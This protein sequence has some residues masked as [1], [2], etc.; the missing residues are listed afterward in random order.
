MSLSIHRG[1]LALLAGSLLAT[2]CS[3]RPLGQIS[4]TSLGAAGASS[5]RS[6]LKAT[7]LAPGNLGSGAN[8]VST[9]GGGIVST[10]GG[11]IIST[12]GGGLVGTQPAAFGLL[13]VVDKFKPV[14]NA[15]VTVQDLS[16]KQ[17]A[18]A[19]TD[20]AGQCG[21]DQLPRRQV[22]TLRTR[23]EVDGKA[24]Y[25]SNLSSTE[26]AS[27]EAIVD[28]I[29]VLVE[30]KFFTILAGKS[31]KTQ[32]VTFALLKKLWM[33]INALEVDIP[34][35]MLDGS[36]TQADLVAFYDEIARQHPE[37][38]PAVDELFRQI[39]EGV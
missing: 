27:G 11:G 8:I 6:A 1:L 20:D 9:Y 18:T 13:A 2:A 29:G 12:Y 22:V 26:N 21:W 7:V 37:L 38:K 24:I 28:P 35:A 33:E 10:Y 36:K 31:L 39:N 32:T 23:I 25:L 4:V 5:L 19:T 30:A 34:V 15:V 14:K 16:G 17:L 3:V